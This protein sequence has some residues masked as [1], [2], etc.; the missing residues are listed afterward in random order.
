MLNETSGSLGIELPSA[1]GGK[2]TCRKDEMQSIPP[3]IAYI[4][5]TLILNKLFPTD[6]KHQIN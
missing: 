5:P 1:L 3:E 4:S 6:I 2:A